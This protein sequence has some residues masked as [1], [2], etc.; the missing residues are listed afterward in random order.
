MTSSNRSV[1]ELS[2]SDT[3]TLDP[4]MSQKIHLRFIRHLASACCWK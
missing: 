2:L 3:G 1:F 4:I